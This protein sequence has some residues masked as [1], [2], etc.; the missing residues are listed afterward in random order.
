MKPAENKKTPWPEPSEAALP[1][2]LSQH[3]NV[4]SWGS[5]LQNLGSAAESAGPDRKSH[6]EVR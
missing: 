5:S 2:L 6:T 1:R 3:S 4:L